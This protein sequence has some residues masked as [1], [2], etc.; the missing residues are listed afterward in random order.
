MVNLPDLVA[1]V[2]TTIAEIYL[3]RFIKFFE[4]TGLVIISSSSPFC[5]LIS[6]SLPEGAV[7]TKVLSVISILSNF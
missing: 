5:S 1:F 3:V 2:L 6:K 7:N 4:S